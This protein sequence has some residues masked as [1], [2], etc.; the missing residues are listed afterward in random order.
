MNFDML[1]DMS[2]IDE[3]SFDNKYDIYLRGWNLPE[4]F[5][6]K[7][8][9]EFRDWMDDDNLKIQFLMVEEEAFTCSRYF[10]GQDAKCEGYSYWIDFHKGWKKGQGKCTHYQVKVT[11]EN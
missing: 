8:V 5:K 3:C 11:N 7:I 4:E 1:Q 2:I 6:E 9:E 10:E